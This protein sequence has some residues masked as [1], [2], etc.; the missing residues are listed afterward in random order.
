M[1]ISQSEII[2]GP[3]LVCKRMVGAK[4]PQQ[5]LNGRVMSKSRRRHN[6]PHGRV[7]INGAAL[8]YGNPEG[9]GLN[10]HLNAKC[11]ECRD[12]FTLGWKKP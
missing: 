10:G 8:P 5:I 3:C 11:I 2:K 7:C 6:C 9:T 12:G 4:R 1:S